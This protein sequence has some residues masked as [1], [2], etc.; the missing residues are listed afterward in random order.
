MTNTHPLGPAPV[1]IHPVGVLPDA[2]HLAAS[3]LPGTE[4][5]GAV[6]LDIESTSFTPSTFWHPDYRLRLVQVAT[7]DEA[8][9]LDPYDPSTRD[10][11]SDD[12]I[13]LI[14]HTDTDP[15]ALD[16]CLGISDV[17]DRWFDTFTLAAFVGYPAGE[18]GLKQLAA[19]HGMPE[20]A[21]AD[22][23]LDER[24][25]EMMKAAGLTG[26]ALAE[27]HPWLKPAAARP[28]YGYTNI[29]IDDP[30]YLKYSGLDAAAVLRL[31]P[32]LLR[33]VRAP[34]G[35][36]EAE[37]QVARENA[38]L[39]VRGVAID[40]DLLG[41]VE[42]EST[43]SFEAAREAFIAH[44]GVKPNSP[45]KVDWFAEHG[46]D[47]T[48]WHDVGGPLTKTGGP[49]FG[50]DGWKTLMKFDL[51]DA[52]RKAA[53]LYGAFVAHQNEALTVT[54]LKYATDPSGTLHPALIPLGTDTGRMSSRAPNVQNLKGRMRNVFVARPGHVFLSIDFD[55]LEAKM[56][57]ALSQD[58][59]LKE[60][61]DYRADF[62][63]TTA[64]M[65]NAPRSHG[66][67]LNF[68]VLFG[69][70]AAH[71]SEML[72]ISLDE[73]RALLKAWWR[74]YPEVSRLNTGL[75]AREDFVPLIDGREVPVPRITK[76]ERAG[77]LRTYANLN[78]FIQGS[79]AIVVK[80][81]WLYIAQVLGL[82]DTVRLVIHDELILEVREGDADAVV[83]LLEGM[84]FSFLEVEFTA[85]AAAL[86]DSAGV[87]RWVK[88]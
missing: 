52:G 76:G 61:T 32:Y 35:A 3:R 84:N 77:E 55:G 62:H 16:V 68:S 12:R 33:K 5:I 82:G 42:E 21:E 51:D 14:S 30:V 48:R 34:R 40:T 17:Y 69:S 64:D 53:E 36:L 37:M 63:Q 19:E 2:D 65:I 80:A 73:A 18:R 28:F 88:S 7:V 9:L 1:T 4:M 79:S 66:K 38:R 86:R 50:K 44:T 74:A 27:L 10:L 58:S 29:P 23:A 75:K 26:K 83:A 72:G 78:Y 70:G 45:K 11:L 39:R 6:G 25:A 22:A 54:Q 47:F 31:V 49:S 13:T 71:I 20:L 43:T 81:A 15:V 60:A 59:K 8:W 24:F 56:A 85:E 41:K 57:A 87:S 46:V 67:T